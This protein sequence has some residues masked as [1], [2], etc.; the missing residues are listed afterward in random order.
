MRQESRTY[1]GVCGVV[2]LLAAMTGTPAAAQNGVLTDPPNTSS[3]G[4]TAAASY[5]PGNIEAVNAVN[6]SMTLSIPAAHL[7]PGPAGFGAGVSLV[8]NS[9]IFDAETEVPTGKP[10]VLR[11]SYVPSAHGGGWQY[12]YRYT[13]WSQ[14][15]VSV[16]NSATCGAVTTKEAANWYKT[17]LTTPDGANHA[18]RLISAVDQGD[19]TYG[20]ASLST[21][22]AGGYAIYDFA[23]YTNLNCG[24]SR[25]RFTGT[26]V[27]TTSDS[28]HIRVEANTA[29]NTWIAYFP[30]G[31]RAGGPINL[32]GQPHA[33][34]SDATQV[35]DR[36]GNTLTITGSC[37]V[38]SA[39]TE[40]LTDAQ[41]RSIV[42]SYS[43]N[44]GGTWTDTITSPGPNGE[45]TTN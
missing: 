4:A 11:I 2:A 10:S 24:L 43:S 5:T 15:R 42:V 36:N 26:L 6:G 12:S 20:P 21:D 23:G 31:T 30:D 44:A 34:D 35:T 39:C 13:L 9:A 17:F 3:G 22:A 38:G 1:K 7:P 27:F 40:T 28:T 19:T 25:A 41:G 8:Y 14:T 45:V 29:N 16:F 37:A 18:L 33:T 32:T